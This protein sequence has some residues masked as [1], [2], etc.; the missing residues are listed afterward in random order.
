MKVQ[1]ARCR[2]TWFSHSRDCDSCMLVERTR[3]SGC[4][5]PLDRQSLLVEPVSRFVQDAEQTGSEVGALTA[6]GEAHVAGIEA[7][8]ERMRREI[9][10]T[11]IEVEADLLAPPTSRT[12]AGLAREG[13]EAALSS[14][15][16]PESAAALTIA[17]ELG[18]EA[19]EQRGEA[20]GAQA[21]LVLVEQA[22]VGM[23]ADGADLRFLAAQLD[24]ALE[25]RREQ[26][27]ALLAAR[28]LPGSGRRCSR[29][30]PAPAPGARECGWRA[31]SR[32]WRPRAAR[33]R[34]RRDRP[35]RAPP[36]PRRA[37][38]ER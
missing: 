11:A 35:A 37:A 7:G 12:R 5:P 8:A 30:P 27:E 17:G 36:R 21:R 6:P 26:R 28:A 25:R 33:D 24:D 20:R 4:A 38:R 14:T 9:E 18:G 22:V 3:P 13:A 34:C 1:N 32:G 15:S 16:T 19:V 2:P 10:P 31:R 29:R 23:V